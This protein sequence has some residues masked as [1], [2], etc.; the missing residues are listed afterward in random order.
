MLG[1]Y[2]NFGQLGG[3]APF[4]SLSQSAVATVAPQ[5]RLDC[6][7]L[8]MVWA[9][10]AFVADIHNITFAVLCFSHRLPERKL[11]WTIALFLAECRRVAT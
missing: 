11:V 2:Q 4:L 6:Q 9:K 1:F 7:R 8:L 10:S 5:P 3:K